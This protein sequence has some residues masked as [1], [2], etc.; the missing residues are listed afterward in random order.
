M[1]GAAP[2]VSVIRALERVPP[3]SSGALVRERTDGTIAGALLVERGRVCWAMSQRYALRLTDL[4]AQTEA[5]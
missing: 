4:L 1:I 2:D 5:R 3:N